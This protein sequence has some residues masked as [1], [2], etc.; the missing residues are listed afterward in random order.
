[1]ISAVV[2][3][4]TLTACGT[5][6]STEL[7][8]YDRF[9]AEDGVLP[10]SDK[11]GECDEIKT[12]YHHG[13]YF[14]FASDSYILKAAYSAEA[15]DEALQ[16]VKSEYTFQKSTMTDK[17]EENTLSPTFSL[18]GY[19]FGV[20]ALNIYCQ[21]NSE[22]PEEIYFIGVNQV[23]RTIA[24]VHFYDPDLDVAESLPYILTEY[25]GWDRIK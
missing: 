22:Y 11:L 24:Y 7:A 3:L 19:D 23:K 17:A 10:T 6:D 20:L 13:S 18:D 16:N 4:L 8:V 14:P 1:M 2:L 21:E 12:L 15:F 25:C 9:A 5:K